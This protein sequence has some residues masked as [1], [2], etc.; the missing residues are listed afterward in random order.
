MGGIGSH[1]FVELEPWSLEF[2]DEGYHGECKYCVICG[3]SGGEGG[4]SCTQTYPEDCHGYCD[5]GFAGLDAALEGDIAGVLA[6][7]IQAPGRYVVNVPRRS[8]QILNCVGEFIANLP[9]EDRFDSALLLLA[10]KAAV[11]DGAAWATGDPA[12]SEHLLASR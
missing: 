9:L 7:A 8:I 3:S 12:H 2:N 10:G 11:W 6:A 5:G 4:E 1:V